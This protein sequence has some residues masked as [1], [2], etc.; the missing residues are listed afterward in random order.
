M[1]YYV[2]RPSEILFFA[3]FSTNLTIQEA[4]LY[5]YKSVRIVDYT[6]AVLSGHRVSGAILYPQSCEDYYSLNFARKAFCSLFKK[7]KI[8]KSLQFQVWLNLIW[9]YFL[10]ERDADLFG[11]A[12]LDLSS[13]FF[14]AQKVPSFHIVTA[15]AFIDIQNSL[16]E[17]LFVRC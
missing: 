8:I 6:V 2:P 12:V 13:T 9:F 1:V 11:L 7:N 17:K 16:V 14:S 3:Q 4:T 5:K 15:F 10:N